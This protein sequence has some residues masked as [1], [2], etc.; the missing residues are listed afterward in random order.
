MRPEVRAGREAT[1]QVPGTWWFR[2]AVRWLL[3]LA[4]MWAV[5]F[6]AYR[7]TERQIKII[8]VRGVILLPVSLWTEGDLDL[9][10][11]DEA[12]DPF[13]GV[14]FV[15]D[16]RAVSAFPFWPVF[17]LMPAYLVVR[18]VEGA[19]PDDDAT[20]WRAQRRAAQASMALTV[21]LVFVVVARRHGWTVA[22][23]IAAA[24]GFGSINWFVLSQLAF[25]NGLVQLWVAAAL[26]AGL[27]TLPP[28]R[29]GAAV[30]LALL[31]VATFYRLN[32]LAFTGV[33]ALFL[34]V[35]MRRRVVVPLGVAAVVAAAMA[36]ANLAYV[37]HPLGFYGIMSARESFPSPTLALALVGNL[38]SPARG[39]L[40]FSPWVC[41]AVL[42]LIGRRDRDRGVLWA[43]ALGCLAHLVLTSNFTRWHG[44][45]SMGPRLTADL[46]PVWAVLAAAGLVWCRHRRW[47]TVLAG[48]TIVVAVTIAAGHAFS[49]SQRWEFTP[50]TS[51]VAPDR[52]FD[53]RDSLVLAPFRQGSHEDR[54]PIRL[55]QPQAGSE[56]RNGSVELRWR[57][58]G[59][60]A[61]GYLVDVSI[62]HRPRGTRI[63]VETLES[64]GPDHLTLTVDALPDTFDTGQPLAWRVRAVDEHGRVVARSGWRVLFWSP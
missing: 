1:G 7:L 36:A 20:L 4:G 27:W 50:V 53:W 30:S 38:V 52:L 58:P 9:D 54:F 18:L 42:A 21:V 61:A 40:V 15:H 23:P 55:D 12:L 19:F 63:S 31:V 34:L 13:P 10:E 5:V 43:L 51:D 11:F 33:W 16:G 25:S 28:S 32:M 57:D 49:N 48:L 6:S 44:G 60:P 62:R 29:T 24:F 26:V 39:L 14:T 47:A 45:G 41:L 2:P 59:G 3:I 64:D 56:H 35:T 22:L 8:D 17:Q 37:G 46:L